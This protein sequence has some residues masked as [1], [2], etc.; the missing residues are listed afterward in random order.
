M[1]HIALERPACPPFERLEPP[2]QL[3]GRRLR[4]DADRE[5]TAL[6]AILFDL[7]RCQTL[8]HR[9]SQ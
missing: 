6:L 7:G 3:C 5:D 8:R 1:A 9:S 2:P 4:H